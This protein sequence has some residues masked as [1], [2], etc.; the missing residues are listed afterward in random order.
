VHQ[1]GIAVILQKSDVTNRDARAVERKI[2]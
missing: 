1:A 2:E